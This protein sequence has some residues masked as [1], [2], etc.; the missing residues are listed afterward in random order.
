MTISRHAQDRGIVPA[1]ESGQG[2]VIPFPRPIPCQRLS[3]TGDEYDDAIRRLGFTQVGFAE[4]A[5]IGQRTSRTYAAKGPPEPLV[6]LIKTLEQYHIPGGWRG[7]RI[8]EAPM[9][10]ETRE[11]IGPSINHL[12][13]R[14]IEQHWDP[15]TIAD[16]LSAIADDLRAEHAPDKRKAGSA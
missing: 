11:A 6:L 3:M 10:E 2:T 7:N 15:L 9:V 5:G 13:E 14:A 4:F 1:D 16:T 8:R 12:I